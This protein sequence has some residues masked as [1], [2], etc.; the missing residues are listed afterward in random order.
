MTLM[1]FNLVRFWVLFLVTSY[2]FSAFGLFS[3][4]CDSF[5]ILSIHSAILLCFYSHILLQKYFV[6]FTSCGWFFFYT[7]ATDLLPK[8]SF[9]ILEYPVFLVLLDCVPISFES[10]FLRQYFL[11]NFLQWYC[12]FSLLLLSLSVFSVHCFFEHFSFLSTL[13]Y[14]CFF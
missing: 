3:V 14:G 5:F 13:E 7:F 10:A 8:F 1:S 11:V 2:I 4:P 9:A 6:S 12:Q